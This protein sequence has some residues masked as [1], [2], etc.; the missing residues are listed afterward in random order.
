[1]IGLEG[2]VVSAAS[3]D[4][5]KITVTKGNAEYSTGV[6]AYPDWDNLEHMP[7]ESSEV[8][9]VSSTGAEKGTKPQRFGL[10]PPEALAVVAAHY[11][12]GAAKYSDHNWRKGYEWSKSYD[13][14]QRHSN[15][16]WAG[17]DIDAETGS[18]HMAAVAFHALTLIT[19]MEEHREFD[20]RYKGE[21]SNSS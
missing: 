3:Y 16:F 15:A 10:I 19:F 1:M 12:V 5:A 4:Y 11:G 7:V 8:R 18:P 9:S 2:I 17:E 14:L 21:L 20:D 13:A 6:Y